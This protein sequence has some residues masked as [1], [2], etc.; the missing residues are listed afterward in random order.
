MKKIISF[1]DHIKKE[2]D[3][4][5]ETMKAIYGSFEEFL[6]NSVES[7]EYKAWIESI[8]DRILSEDE[9]NIIAKDIHKFGKVFPNQIHKILGIICHQQNVDMPEVEGCLTSKYWESKF[10]K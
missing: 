4:K 7:G 6:D 8:K 1:K 3:L 5:S 2:Y 10:N 9:M